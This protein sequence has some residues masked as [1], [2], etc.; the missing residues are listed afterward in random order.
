[1]AALTACHSRRSGVSRSI[2]RADYGTFDEA[3]GI[4][5]PAAPELAN[6]L[7]NHAPMAIEAMCALGRGDATLP[8]LERYRRG[9]VPRPVPQDRIT[10]AN[11]REALGNPRRFADWA[12]FFSIEL[13]ERPW[14]QVVDRWTARLAPGIVAPE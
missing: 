2:M 8:W 14:R 13:A 10:E 3:L 1:R 9:F 7:S 5:A 6:T 12:A 11:W 4:I